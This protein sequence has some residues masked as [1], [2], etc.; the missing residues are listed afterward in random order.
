MVSGRGRARR[1][2]PARARA[3]ARAFPGHERHALRRGKNEEGCKKFC[4]NGHLA[5]DCRIA[6]SDDDRREEGVPGTLSAETKHLFAWT[7]EIGRIHIRLPSPARPHNY[8]DVSTTMIYTH[9]LNKGGH[10]VKSPL[11]MS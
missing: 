9:V 5:G 11:D 10:A 4:V 8:Q 1:A 6:R 7:Y 3:L 2:G